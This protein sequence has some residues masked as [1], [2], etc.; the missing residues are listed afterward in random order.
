VGWQQHD[1]QAKQ[2]ST[3]A[4]MTTN[5]REEAKLRRD[6]AITRRNHTNFYDF[7]RHQSEESSGGNPQSGGADR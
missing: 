7:Y 2:L 6:N 5:T 3:A 1:T 4:T